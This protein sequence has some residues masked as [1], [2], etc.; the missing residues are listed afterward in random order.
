MHMLEEFNRGVFDYLIATDTSID[1]GEEDEDNGDDDDVDVDV[2]EG[3]L[4]TVDEGDENDDEVDEEGNESGGKMNDDDD[5][6]DDNDDDNDDDDNDDDDEDDDSQS[7]TRKRK[8]PTN[9][10][11]KKVTILEEGESGL[12]TTKNPSLQNKKAAKSP[13]LPPVAPVHSNRRPLRNKTS[14]SD[15]G[16]SRGIDFQ[17]VKFVINF[18]F[19]ST[20][21]AYTHRIGRTARGGASG[22]A[23]S[24]VTKY[25]SGSSN[26][27]AKAQ[28]LYNCKR[29]LL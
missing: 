16:V 20:A 19:P 12:D 26:E 3:Y 29:V 5:D 28:V 18:D 23:L 4:E 10:K 7:N 13:S 21:A 24:F 17:G 25:E 22:T 9:Q 27:E 8:L 11:S 15:Y 2:E 1:Q 14:T 6:D